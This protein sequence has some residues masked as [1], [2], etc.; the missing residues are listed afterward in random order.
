MFISLA[1][2]KSM[3]VQQACTHFQEKRLTAFVVGKNVLGIFTEHDIIKL[4]AQDKNATDLHVF[5]VMTP[6][7]VCVHKN[8]TESMALEIM[9]AA[10]F[11]HLPCVHNNGSLFSIL[12]VVSV[13]RALYKKEIGVANVLSKK[14]KHFFRFLSST[15]AQVPPST[16]GT[17]EASNVNWSSVDK[18][19]LLVLKPSDTVLVAACHMIEQQ[20][21]ALLVENEQGSVIGIVTESDI[22]R[23]VVSRGASASSTQLCLIMT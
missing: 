13:S 7:P 20:V 14:M 2:A 10:K 19:D 9:R 12:D 22:V 16:S 21:S 18:H 6:K 1:N 4:V 15:V 11:R 8:I 17:K 3:T 5:D 23:R